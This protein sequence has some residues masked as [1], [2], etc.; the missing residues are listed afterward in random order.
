MKTHAFPKA[1]RILKR[2]EYL[3]LSKNGK[4]L[5]SKAFIAIID[6]DSIQNRLGV[7]V[8]KKVGKAAERNRIKR[9]IREYFRLNRDKI[10][11]FWKINIIAKKS[12]GEATHQEVN[13][14]LNHI[15][16]TLYKAK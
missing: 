8:S 13:A 16:K 3:A 6:T 10:Q 4:R 5:Y 7:T 9:F 14:S 2:K 15:F 1:N 12:A 11:G